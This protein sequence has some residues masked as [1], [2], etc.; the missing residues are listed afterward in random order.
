MSTV[1]KYRLTEKPGSNV[2]TVPVYVRNGGHWCDPNDENTGNPMRLGWTNMSADSL[3]SGA[4]AMSRQ[5]V[6]DYIM[7]IHA[8]NPLQ[9]GDDP[10]NMTNMTDAEATTAAENWYDTFVS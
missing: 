4:T 7:S 9:T 10:E 1:V 6:I 5:N 3:P 2:K 8:T